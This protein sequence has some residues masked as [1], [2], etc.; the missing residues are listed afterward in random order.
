MKK[1]PRSFSRLELR[2]FASYLAIML[3]V[4]V[5]LVGFSYRSFSGFHSR[6]L[7][8]GYQANLHLVETAQEEMVTSLIAI[9]GQMTNNDITP[10]KYAQDPVKASRIS[11]KLNAYRA[12]NDG[13]LCFRGCPPRTHLSRGL[14]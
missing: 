9:A 12:V 14:P 7:L 3:I 13:P 6:I 1:K 10:V 2:Y 8:N 5:A 4:M 11:G